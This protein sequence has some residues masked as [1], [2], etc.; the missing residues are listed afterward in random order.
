MIVMAS[1]NLS[2]IASQPIAV[3]DDDPTVRQALKRLLL[4]IGF[5]V[6][7]YASANE[8]L[9]SLDLEKQACLIL[10]I[11][12][13]GLTGL[14]LQKVIATMKRPIPIIFIT[15]HNEE[16]IQSTVMEM[17]AAGFLE[18]PFDDEALIAL[19]QKA[20]DRSDVS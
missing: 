19:V 6:T 15:A 12:M 7:T 18:K 10:D 13:P 16:D 1:V 2:Q 14:D 4:S 20:L 17:G 5:P 8:F 3:V 9:R 11:Q